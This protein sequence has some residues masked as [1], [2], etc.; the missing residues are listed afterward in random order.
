MR[1]IL[2]I[3]LNFTYQIGI[4]QN[5]SNAQLDSLG[6]NVPVEN[7]ES[8]VKLANY[9]QKITTNEN[10]LSRLVYSWV[11]HH[12][13][14]DDDSFNNRV[15]SD[16][17]AA[18]VF[19]SRK[20]VCAGYSSVFK[21]ICDTLNLPCL[22]IDGF[23]KGYGFTSGM[24]VTGTNHSWNA[25]KYDDQWH[26]LDATWGSGYAESING[27]AKSK[28]VY[29][30]YWFDVNPKEFVFN[31]FPDSSKYQ[32]L[33]KKYTRE[34][35]RKLI[36]IE[37]NSAFQ[38]GFN[39]DSVLIKMQADPKFRLPD[40]FNLENT[41]F[42]I[43]SAPYNKTIKAASSHYFEIEQ[44]S[45]DT[46]VL[47]N[48]QELIELDAKS[49][50]SFSKTVEQLKQGDLHIGVLRGEAVELIVTYKVI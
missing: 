2:L 19:K 16:Q 40:V 9:F 20:A 13:L 39:V 43:K 38:L 11:A 8:I 14:Y 15:F 49:E 31:H 45:N 28:S 17:S 12:I 27:K 46:I 21:A 25:V 29:N 1:I 3:L 50:N 4:A 44:Y 6:K 23:A 34:Q 37:S 41:N 30:V 7:E 42:K 26:L 32:F 48:N 22:S 10:Y 24:A 33:T 18:F 5:Y 35:Y 36:H 47:L